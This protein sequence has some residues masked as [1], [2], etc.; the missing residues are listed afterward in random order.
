MAYP[1]GLHVHLLRRYVKAQNKTAAK[2]NVLYNSMTKNVVKI[3]L[4][5][6][7]CSRKCY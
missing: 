5:K 1:L 2:H 4:E 3:E 7:F 6:L